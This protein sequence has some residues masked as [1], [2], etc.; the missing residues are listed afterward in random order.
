MNIQQISAILIFAYLGLLSAFG[1]PFAYLGFANK[2]Y[3]SEL[4]LTLLL[5]FLFFRRDILKEAYRATRLTKVLVLS[6][7]A[8][9]VYGFIRLVPALIHSEWPRTDSLK[10]FVL[11]T[12]SL[13]IFFPL[14][15]SKKE[16][17]TLWL[18]ILV[19]P[20][21]LQLGTWKMALESLAP[22]QSN[23]K[24]SFHVFNLSG[25]EATSPLFP[26]I[27]LFVDRPWP[28]LIQFFYGAPL[29]AQILFY[30]KRNWLISF[31]FSFSAVSR[32]NIKRAARYAA[33]TIVG[34]ALS[35]VIFLKA[36]STQGLSMKDLMN[37]AVSDA[38]FRFTHGE[39]DTT[40]TGLAR[41]ISW[42]YH[43]WASAM[44]E[45]KQKPL[46]G[47]GFG[48]PIVKSVSFGYLFID[49]KRI[50]GPHNSFITLLYRLGV[51]GVLAFLS[52]WLTPLLL[53]LF[54]AVFR[55]GDAEV[56]ASA[57]AG[58][59]MAFFC[60]FNICL[61]SPQGGV[62]FWLFL[63]LLWV[64]SIKRQSEPDTPPRVLSPR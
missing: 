8:F 58:I 37:I 30:V 59:C 21:V 3:V 47:V 49:G 14:V 7:I 60:A 34:M 63:G 4:F 27:S 44:Q 56:L 1:K 12:Y 15:L 9:C 41:F 54:S 5:T 22:T 18:C 33:V 39:V 25:N 16:R 51:V 23:L 40:K 57:T 36:A 62:P 29:S 50:S 35:L 55:N 53:T 20:A 2:V 38:S 46:L 10:Q 32:Q 19:A 11:I 31:L 6:W 45:W 24:F 28:L 43:L 64:S 52:I 61:E 26:L 42:R 48:E 13:W 17:K